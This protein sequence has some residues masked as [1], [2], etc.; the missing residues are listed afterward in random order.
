MDSAICSVLL[1]FKKSITF[2]RCCCNFWRIELKCFKQLALVREQIFFRALQIFYGLALLVPSVAFAG[3]QNLCLDGSQLAVLWLTPF[4][5]LL[6]SLALLPAVMPGLWH[7]HFGK[8]TFSWSLAV[9][10]PLVWAQGPQP[11][12]HLVLEVLLHEYVPFIFL[13]ATLYILSSSLHID[14]YAPGKPLQNTV[15]LIV[16]SLLSNFIGTTGAA[17]LLIHPLLRMNRERVHKTH[18]VVFFIFM[19]CNIGGSLSP[20]GDPP[21]FIGFLNGV[22]FLWPLLNLFKPFLMVWVPVA[23]LYFCLEA[24]Y[25]YPREA[26]EVAP[27]EAP[28]MRDKH[29]QKSLKKRLKV[30]GKEQIFLFA[31]ALGAVL[32]SGIWNPGIRLDFLGVPLDLQDLCRDVL[33]LGCMVA[34]LMWG[35][36]EHRKKNGFSWIPLQEVGILFVG[37]FITAAPVVSILQAGSQ[38]CL[39]T[40][41]AWMMPGGAPS[42]LHFFWVTGF[43]S[44]FLDNAPTYLAFFHVAGGDATLLTSKLNTTLVAI[45]MGSVF[46]GALTYIGNAPNLMVRAIA[47]EKGVQMPS[48]LGYIG[49]A[50]CCLLPFYF[51][52]SLLFF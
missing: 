23:C 50:V 5:G 46:M 8:I 12:F 29:P 14:V 37:I 45:S 21:L 27:G 6:L 3:T 32:L 20:V 39:D 33:L 36:S 48:F 15:F 19:V 16:G 1:F 41:F 4:V 47:E 10:I 30:S 40:I 44:A 42:N 17:M 31:T 43:L 49:W 35:K 2:N 26:P 18:T 28:G 38:G 22:P 7:R 51:F 11:A 13:I 25:F 9:F 24:F 34:S 52:L